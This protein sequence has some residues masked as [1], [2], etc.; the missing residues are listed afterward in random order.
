MIRKIIEKERRR[1]NK[2][3]RER[4]LYIKTGRLSRMGMRGEWTVW[5]AAGFSLFRHVL[6]TLF[7]ILQKGEEVKLLAVGTWPA[8]RVRAIWSCSWARGLAQD[9][10][11]Q[12]DTRCIPISLENVGT[13]RRAYID[14]AGFFDV[15]MWLFIHRKSIYIY[16]VY[17][18][19]MHIYIYVFKFILR[20]LYLWCT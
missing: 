17:T 19:L 10:E 20:C 9:T 3:E 16:T 6:T 1:E 12:W 15:N 2:R 8:E 13:E 14:V 4:E 5:D 18:F 11:T 7:V